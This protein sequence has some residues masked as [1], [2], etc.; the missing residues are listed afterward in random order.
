[1]SQLLYIETIRIPPCI[2]CL[3]A[4]FSVQ[5]YSIIIPFKEKVTT[6]GCQGL[7]LRRKDQLLMST[8]VSV[9]LKKRI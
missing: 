1:M 8:E 3:T 2:N 9:T 4:R 6:W 7:Q 5:M